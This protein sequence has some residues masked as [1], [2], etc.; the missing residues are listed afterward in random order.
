MS[1][2]KVRQQSNETQ[3]GC[4][5]QEGEYMLSLTPDG[6]LYQR[7]GEAFTRPYSEVKFTRAISRKRIKDTGSEKLYFT[8]PF[9][10]SD[11]FNKFCF[12]ENGAIYRTRELCGAE[13]A[14]AEEAIRQF[15]VPVSDRRKGTGGIVKP[16][17]KTFREDGGI[18]HRLVAIAIFVFVTLLIGAVIMYLIN[19][20]LH[21][22]TESLAL[23]FL[24]FCLPCLIPIIIKSQELGSKIKIY[25][26]GVQLK[27]RSKSGYGGTTSPFAIDK[28]FFSWEEVECVERVQSQV[29]YEVK[30]RLGYCV[31]TVPDFNGL[32]DYISSRFPQECKGG[33]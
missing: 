10:S 13:R 17:L 18:A 28:A 4:S 11:T 19:Y 26:K 29:R 20:F 6:V 16:P 24:V 9:P 15:S 31:Y 22:D 2:K 3:S 7:E 8:A 27:I 21:T 1:R 12:K 23:V 30:F 5:F 33:E 14:R 25:E 32:Y